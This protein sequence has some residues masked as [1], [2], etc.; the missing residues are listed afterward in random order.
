MG[1]VEE[2][3]GVQFDVHRPHDGEKNWH[4]HLLVTT[5]RFAKDG[6][7]LDQK[8]RDLSPQVRGGQKHYILDESKNPISILWR[9]IQDQYFAENEIG[10][11]VDERNINAQVHLGPGVC[12][13]GLQ[14]KKT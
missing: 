12:G 13:Q 1:F 8:A 2:G 14:S 4:A 10:I 7:S 11:T 5:R 6:Q 9:K 3:L